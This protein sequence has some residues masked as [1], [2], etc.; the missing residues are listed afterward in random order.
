[1]MRRHAR[2]ASVL[3]WL[4]ACDQAAE[5]DDDSSSAG[6]DAAP[7]S[8]DALPAL[9]D[10]A[11]AGVDAEAA[12]ACLRTVPVATRA[13]LATALGAAQAG[14]CIVLADGDYTGFAIARSGTAQ[15]PIVISAAHL[16]RAVVR[17]GFVHFNHVDHVTLSG[18]TI[19]G[20]GG[21]LSIDGTQRP[22]G[23][24]LVSSNHCRVTRTTFRLVGAPVGAKWLM[25]A[26]ASD[27][28]RVDHCEFGPLSAAGNNVFV[29]PAGKQQIDGVTNPT[30]RTPW[31][32]GHGPFNPNIARHTRIDH[33]WFH[34]KAASTSEVMVLGGAGM[35]GDYQ[36][37]FSVVEYNLFESCDGDPE[38]ISVKASS[39]TI[40]YN[41]IKT[42][43]G[44]VSLRAGNSSAIHGNFFLQGGKA[45]A[46]GIKIYERDHR[47]FNN[48]IDNASEY[49]ILVGGGDAYDGGGF[50]HAQVLRATIV[51]NTIV[52]ADRRPVRIS[53]GGTLAPRDCEFAN[54]LLLGSGDK[55]IVESA[56]PTHMT[57][58][59][60]VVW[61]S[62]GG[63]V[64]LDRPADQFRVLDPGLARSG[65]IARL[66]ASLPATGG[67]F[68]FVT[69]DADGQPRGASADVGADQ[70]APASTALPRRPLLPADVG[71]NAP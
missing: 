13:T 46:G 11:D 56:T 25:I 33:N 21:R 26:D 28:N 66:T 53:H 30:D 35:A 8:L 57:Y 12:S 71:P 36:D 41:T 38:I 18:L 27:S 65:G 2:V 69:V 51:H 14:D 32:E 1:M 63:S 68:S 50:A 58:K 3:L 64:G 52:K 43:S 54:N 15:N 62:G 6:V 37:T 47:I 22:V 20:P 34:D 48:Y 44:L 31:A 16:G 45:G 10:P 9:P 70:F 60:N 61:P 4:V 49:P 55:L 7:A 17:T 67:S 24:V 42:S 29:W 19:T 59:G 23:V 39:T 40:R 5:L